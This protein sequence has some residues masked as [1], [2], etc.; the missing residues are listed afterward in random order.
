MTGYKAQLPC[1]VTSS[2]ANDAVVMVLWYRDWQN[3]QPIYSVAVREQSSISEA[4]LWSDPGALGQRAKMKT[5][6]SPTE[7]EIEPVDY[8][9]RGVYWCRVDFTES[10]TRYQKINLTV[11]GNFCLF[12]LIKL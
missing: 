3:G 7:L 11:I 9:D 4:K 5:H 12:V 10:P 8:D 6:L 1:D 2:I